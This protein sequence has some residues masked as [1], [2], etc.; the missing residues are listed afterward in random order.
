MNKRIQELA[1]AAENIADTKH[2]D[3]AIEGCKSD[4]HELFRQEFAKLIVEHCVSCF[5]DDLS[6]MRD[7]TGTAVRH[8]LRREFG[9][10]E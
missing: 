9:L 3:T 4:W 2:L 8:M 10:V 5:A 1:S 7:Y 6:S